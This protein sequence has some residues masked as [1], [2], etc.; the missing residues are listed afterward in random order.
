MHMFTSSPRFFTVTS[1]IRNLD[2]HPTF[3]VVPNL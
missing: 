2:R 3:P 1:H